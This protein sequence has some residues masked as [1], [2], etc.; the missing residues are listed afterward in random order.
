M[1]RIDTHVAMVFLAGSRA[2]KL[3]RSIKLPFLDF[4]TL[5][6]RE[7]ACR[8]EIRLNRRTAPE[9]Y[10]A[11][12]AITAEEGGGLAFDGAGPVV[13]WVV[14]MRRF[15][16]TKLLDQMAS[17]GD[18]TAADALALAQ[19]IADFHARA[20]PAPDGA[21]AA[22][23]GRVIKLNSEALGRYKDTVFDGASVATLR[24]LSLARLDALGGCLAARLRQGRVR[25]CHGDLHLRNIFLGD[26]GPVIFDALEYDDRLARTDVMYDLAFLLMD[27]WHHGLSELANRLL[28]RYLLLTEDYGGLE[29]LPL[30]LSVRA[31]IRAHASADM[32]LTQAAASQ[33]RAL[34]REALDYLALATVLLRPARPRLVAVGGYSG[35]GK[36]TLA[37]AL[38]PSFRPPPGAIVLRS[39]EVR[40]RLMGVMAEAPLGPEAYGANVNARVYA[41]LHGLAERVLSLGYVA[42]VDAVHDL[43]SG[44]RELGRIA[45]KAGVPFAGY[46]LSAGAKT[47]ARRIEARG[48]DASDATPAVMRRQL[49]RGRPPGNWRHLDSE[50]RPEAIL[51]TVHAELSTAAPA[52]SET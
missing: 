35:S 14:A 8:A 39:D 27:L 22:E 12:R 32:A 21:D 40:K 51:E 34:Q 29:P 5:A 19:T 47:L 7:A 48:P 2:Y 44:R 31:A 36:S 52:V 43:P 28:N 26:Q 9:I 15:D 42:I 24:R 46:W 23:I 10:Q 6:R 1:C 41:E 30:F 17:A 18:L 45:D 37:G 38:A 50:A 3:K 20:E 16:D 49:K 13:D 11:V 25:H 4:T 33:R